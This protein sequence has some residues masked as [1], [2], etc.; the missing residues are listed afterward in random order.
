M[1]SLQIFVTVGK[2]IC[3]SYV[4]MSLSSKSI[5]LQNLKEGFAKFNFIKD[6]RN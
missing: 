1:V 3:I 2:E 4:L 6:K 5:R